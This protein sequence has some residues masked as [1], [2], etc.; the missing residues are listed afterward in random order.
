MKVGMILAVT[1]F[2][3]IHFLL[4]ISLK[5]IIIYSIDDSIYHQAER[6]GENTMT[7]QQKVESLMK[8]A[9]EQFEWGY[10][11]YSYWD[12]EE[13]MK[14]VRNGKC[15]FFCSDGISNHSSYYIPAFRKNS[16]GKYYMNSAMFLDKLNQFE[17]WLSQETNKNFKIE[18][19][20]K[21]LD[22]EG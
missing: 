5:R 11:K 16:K 1:I 21:E 7:R 22:L 4:D 17:N 10:E 12:T 15:F 2:K 8:E 18:Q 19:A 9:G 3:I 6:Q 20:L 13:V 14:N